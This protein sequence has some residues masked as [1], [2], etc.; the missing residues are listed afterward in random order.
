MAKD[1]LAEH[2]G[3]RRNTGTSAEEYGNVRRSRRSYAEDAEEIPKLI[4]KARISIHAGYRQKMAWK[5]H[6]IWLSGFCEFTWMNTGTYAKDAEV[7]Q[8]SQKKY[9]NLFVKA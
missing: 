5:A 8:K 3:G 4:E 2:K 9:Q 7:T 6:G 1:A